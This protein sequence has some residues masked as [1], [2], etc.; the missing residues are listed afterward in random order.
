MRSWSLSRKVLAAGLVP[1]V[2]CGLGLAA[3]Y[4][5]LSDSFDT[6]ARVSHTHEVLAEANGLMVAALAAQ[7]GER[8]YVMVADDGFLEAFRTGTRDFFARLGHLRTLVADDPAQSARL[9]I[10]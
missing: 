8:G 9:D 7:S 1:A 4:H 5:A 6:N 3:V 2:I 10:I